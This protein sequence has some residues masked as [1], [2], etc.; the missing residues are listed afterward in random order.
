MHRFPLNYSV[1]KEI[2]SDDDFQTL[3]HVFEYK[4][5]LNES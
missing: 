3:I 1:R 2:A 4:S 5:V